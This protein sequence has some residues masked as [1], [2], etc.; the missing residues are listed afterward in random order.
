MCLTLSPTGM[1]V[2]MGNDML[3]GDVTFDNDP[4]GL[5]SQYHRI[6]DDEVA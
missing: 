3:L 6:L 5:V 2:I 4:C 1:K